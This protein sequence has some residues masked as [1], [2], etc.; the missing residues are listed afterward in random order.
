MRIE[1][2]LF[3]W[4]GVFTEN[5]VISV[6]KTGILSMLNPE[7][8]LWLLVDI[9]KTDFMKMSGAGELAGRFHKTLYLEECGGSELPGVFDRIAEKSGGAREECLVLDFNLKRAVAAINNR[10]PAA[11][12]TD[13]E[14]IER[15]FLLRRLSSR[16]Y[17]MHKRPV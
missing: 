16:E 13:N 6:T 7:L 4:M 17:I 2:K 9:P 15:E 5:G 11:V 14:H 10:L 1:R 12:V 8:E 3:F